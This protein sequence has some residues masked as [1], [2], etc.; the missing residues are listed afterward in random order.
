[1]RKSRILHAARLVAP[2]L[3][4]ALAG[5]APLRPDY[6]TVAAVHQSQPF[7]GKHAPPLGDHGRTDESN[8]DAAELGARW[9]RGRLFV[10]ANAAYALHESNIAGGPWITTVRAGVRFRVPGAP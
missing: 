10:E 9:E 5:C 3:L 7:V 4:T 1:M 2:L 6:V 8:Y